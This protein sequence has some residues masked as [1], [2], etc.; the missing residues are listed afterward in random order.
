MINYRPSVA[1]QPVLTLT[2]LW[3]LHIGASK[4]AAYD[5]DPLGLS[6]DA[7]GHES[8]ITSCSGTDEVFLLQLVPRGKRDIAASHRDPVIIGKLVLLLVL[9]LGVLIGVVMSYCCWLPRIQAKQIGRSSSPD[10]EPQDLHIPHGINEMVAAMWPELSESA[11]TVVTRMMPAVLE[12]LPAALQAGVRFSSEDI[13]LGDSPVQLSSLKVSKPL[14]QTTA[15]LLENL[16]LNIGLEWNT[17]CFIGLK[18]FESTVGISGV[19]VK[20]Q[21]IVELVGACETS[22]FFLGIRTYFVEPP[23]IEVHWAGAARML[24]LLKNTISNAIAN[25]VA[26][27]MVLPRRMPTIL[28]PG[29]DLFQVQSPAP[30]GMIQLHVDGA[31]NLLAADTNLFSEH[32]SDP[33]FVIQCGAQKYCSETKKSTLSP[34][35]NYT[36]SIIVR[37]ANLQQILISFWDEDEGVIKHVKGDDFLGKISI[38]VSDMRSWGDA[39]QKLELEDEEGAHGQG[40][41]RLRAT[42]RP[43]MLDAAA[44]SDDHLCYIFVGLYGCRGLQEDVQGVLYWFVAECTSVEDGAF[45]SRQESSKHFHNRDAA[46]VN[47]IAENTK[48]VFRKLDSKGVLC[49][50]HR[51]YLKAQNSDVA[52]RQRGMH[53]DKELPQVVFGHAFEFLSACPEKAIVTL[54]LMHSL[55]DSGE[56]ELAR[57]QFPIAD[58]LN[59]RNLTLNFDEPFSPGSEIY[60][61][62][63]FQVRF[64]GAPETLEKTAANEA[65]QSYLR[66]ICK[67]HSINLAENSTKPTMLAKLRGRLSN[68]TC[69]AGCFRS[70]E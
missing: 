57:K 45:D 6:Q 62:A 53:E 37:A 9:L 63:K 56:E 66:P 49:Q 2:C 68:M 29:A 52:D 20:G 16:Q 67:Q 65:S 3:C 64:F 42:W 51:H 15:G 60:F 50:F 7:G 17:N 59:V 43:L 19:N 11:V 32:S 46:Y 38:P 13:S 40:R 33:Y 69:A 25:K 36:Q 48:D 4:V 10:D 14:Q 54:R 61:R 26:E 18:I 35:Y 44:R 22:P 41:I 70:S 5:V 47:G 27:H 39:E 31:E 58:L 23:H 21:L 12:K 34:S 1:V 28:I 8:N 55:G 24:D 30:E